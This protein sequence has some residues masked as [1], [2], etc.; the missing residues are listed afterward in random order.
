MPVTPSHMLPV[1]S[2]SMPWSLWRGSLQENNPKKSKQC[3]LSQLSRAWQSRSRD[4]TKQEARRGRK[5]GVLLPLPCSLRLFSPLYDFF[6]FKY[7][8]EKLCHIKAQRWKLV[9]VSCY[10]PAQVGF[11]E[12]SLMC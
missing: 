7:D 2:C 5:R 1:S 8:E 3:V 6:S 9:Q 11:L 4:K 12:D 10:P